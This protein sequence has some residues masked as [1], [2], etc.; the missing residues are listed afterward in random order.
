M[1]YVEDIKTLPLNYNMILSGPPTS[2]DNQKIICSSIIK[3]S[4]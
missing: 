3:K 2:L 4:S 1:D